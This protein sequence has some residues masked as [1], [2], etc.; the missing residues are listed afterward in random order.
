MRLPRRFKIHT[1]YISVMKLKNNFEV[2][3]SAI[4]LLLQKRI[5]I[6]L[7]LHINITIII[8]PSMT[9]TYHY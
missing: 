8:I 5:G 3:L 2:G 6:S 9:I 1:T 4:L 7:L